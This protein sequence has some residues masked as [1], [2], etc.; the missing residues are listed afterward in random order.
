MESVIVSSQDEIDTH[1]EE[2]SKRGMKPAAMSNTGLPH[3]QARITFLPESAFDTA[4]RNGRD[5]MQPP[6][7][8]NDQSNK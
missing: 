2:F 6:R 7:D 4:W 8:R 5:V 3:G 1:V